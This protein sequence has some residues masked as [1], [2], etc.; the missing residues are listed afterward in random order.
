MLYLEL[1]I[2][3]PFCRVVRLYTNFREGAVLNIATHNIYRYTESTSSRDLG[4]RSI[5]WLIRVPCARG[6]IQLSFL[7]VMPQLLRFHTCFEI[8]YLHTAE[9]II[10][11]RLYQISKKYSVIWQTLLLQ[12]QSYSICSLNQALML[13]RNSYMM[14]MSGK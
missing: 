10:H 11:G 4:L 5:N 7:L 2:Q 14:S 9:A 3:P 1:P 12:N 13:I 6:Y 8:C